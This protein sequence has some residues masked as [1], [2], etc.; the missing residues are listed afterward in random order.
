V[1]GGHPLYTSCVCNHSQ[2]EGQS[3]GWSLWALLLLFPALVSNAKWRRI[4]W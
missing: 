4:S 3:Q 2:T 1:Q